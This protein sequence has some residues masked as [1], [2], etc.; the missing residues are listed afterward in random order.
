MALVYVRFGIDKL[1]QAR[2][3]QI[4]CEG[5]ASSQRVHFNPTM[6]FFNRFVRVYVCTVRR[7]C[8]LS[9]LSLRFPLVSTDFKNNPT[10]FSQ[11]SQVS[12]SGLFSFKNFQLMSVTES[13]YCRLG[14]A[15]AKPIGVNLRK[16]L[17][18]YEPLSIGMVI[19][20][21]GHLVP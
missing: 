18:F 12:Q 21:V 13:L 19:D 20:I 10:T 17:C 16:R 15:I 6:S 9:L 8:R 5:S 1:G 2:P 11:V 3:L 14:R 7:P 4:V